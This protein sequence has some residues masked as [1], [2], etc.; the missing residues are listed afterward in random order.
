MANTFDKQNSPSNEAPSDR[1]HHS[2]SD[3]PITV[4][5]LLD[6]GM[7]PYP[8]ALG[9]QRE[10]HRALI[11]GT[12]GQILICA[13]HPPVITRGRSSRDDTL[14]SSEEDLDRQKIQVFDVER[15]GDITYHGPGQFVAYPILDLHSFK[16]DVGWYMRQLEQ[17]V[18]D[19]LADFNVAAIRIPG[20]TGVWISATE[21]ISSIGVKISRWR[22][23]HGISVNLAKSSE[24]GFKNIVPCG[25]PE[26]RVTSIE[27]IIGTSPGYPGYRDAFIEHF[28]RIFS[29][30]LRASTG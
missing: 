28:S 11:E 24:I 1:P 17:V 16:T 4:A 8:E 13:E 6:L 15:G 27:R 30:L 10:K 26:A 12:G 23:L 5:S 25:L 3:T 14:L 21:K 19:S 29:V 22:T 7:V 18:I 20:K 9:V 2:V